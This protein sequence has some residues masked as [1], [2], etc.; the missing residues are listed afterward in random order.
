MEL[1]NISD[2]LGAIIG[3]SSISDTVFLFLI[4]QM[5][6]NV[7][8]TDS[9]GCAVDRARAWCEMIDTIY[10]RSADCE[11]ALF[12]FSFPANSACSGDP[13]FTFP[14]SVFLTKPLNHTISPPTIV[15]QPLTH[16]L[17]IVLNHQRD[18]LSNV[19][20]FLTR[21]R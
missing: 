12:W 14:S 11:S 4:L 16:F 17:R 6:L 21:I 5:S 13:Y 18:K 9:D 19:L 8:C 1:S 10:H 20:C 3:N 7:K 15:S 2:I